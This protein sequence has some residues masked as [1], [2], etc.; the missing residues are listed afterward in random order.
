VITKTSEQI[1][2]KTI[3][4]PLDG[5]DSS[6]K[7]AMYAIKIAKVANA[8]IICVHAVVNLPYTEYTTAGVV[9]NQYIADTKKQAQEWYD[10]VN[11]AAE[12]AEVRVTAETI[13]DVTS[14]ADSIINYA[15]RNNL[16]LIIIG[17]KGRTGIKKFVLGSVANSVVSHAKCPVLVVR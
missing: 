10:K 16:D 2:L 17:T 15:E 11:A 12:K 5:S 13:L 9:I 6:F 8:K 3:L 4:V 14:V 1:Q 7:A